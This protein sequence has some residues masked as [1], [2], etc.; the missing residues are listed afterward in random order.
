MEFADVVRSRRMTRNF[1]PR[2]VPGEVVDAVLDLARRAPSAGNSGGVEFL[3]LEG[4]DVGAYWEVTL[5][6][7]RR[8]GF[9]WPGLLVAPV[10]VVPCVRPDAYLRRYSEPD[11]ARTG[12]GA[13][14]ARWPVPYWWVDGGAVVQ[15]LLLAATD[16]GLGALFFGIF[17]HTGAV[18][19]RYGVPAELH[20]IGAIALGWL[21]EVQRPSRSAARVRPPLEAV[22]HRRRW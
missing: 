7:E 6:P 16:A 8:A 15:N 19:A 5:A 17:E 11:K 2:P 14:E 21:E 4:D 18:K 10:L 13:D 9:P 20:P 3:V 22:V 12:L 1:E